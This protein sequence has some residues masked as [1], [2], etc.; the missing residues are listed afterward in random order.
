L[1]GFD[2]RQMAAIITA[3]AMVGMAV[4]ADLPQRKLGINGKWTYANKAE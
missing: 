1:G 3:L 2:W 4:A